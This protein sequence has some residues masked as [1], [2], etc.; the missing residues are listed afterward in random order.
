MPIIVSYGGGVNSTA[1]LVKMVEHEIKP[2]AILFADT[3]GEQ[4]ETYS[5]IQYISMW[6][7]SNSFPKIEVVKYKTK[8]G[9]EL[10]LE[11][12]VINNNTLPSI[13]FGFKTCSQKFKITPQEKWIKEHYPDSWSI[14][15][16]I[17][18]DAGEPKRAKENPLEGHKNIYPLIM[19]GMD[20]DKCKKAIID[21][22]LCLPPKSSCFFCPNMK[23]HEILRL[24]DTEKARVRFIEKNATK[25]E[26]IEGLGRSY[27]W[28]DLLNADE[29][30]L[31]LFDDLELYQQPCECID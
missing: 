27:A 1:M 17:G 9:D 6:L 31:D 7:V 12:D 8:H 30:Q 20:R 3:G 18:F 13:A 24:S 16:Y 22:G 14:T 28:T 25:P 26:K 23:K 4:Q 29:A 19:W 11:Q 15:H 10:T 21:S 5:Y 2:D